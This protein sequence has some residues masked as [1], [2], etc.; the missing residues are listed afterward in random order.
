MSRLLCLTELLR[1]L[2]SHNPRDHPAG[3]AGAPT[4]QAQD[5]AV[6]GAAPPL[7][8]LGPAVRRNAGAGYSLQG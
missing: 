8:E 2:T 3:T 5:L 4:G 7:R 1:R 6:L